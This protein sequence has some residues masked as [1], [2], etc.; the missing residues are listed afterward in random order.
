MNIYVSWLQL[1][2]TM[3]SAIALVCTSVG[4]Y[5]I[6]IF[7]RTG[8]KQIPYIHFCLIIFL[9]IFIYLQQVEE[10]SQREYTTISIKFI[11]KIKIILA[12]CKLCSLKYFDLF[13]LLSL[14]KKY[15]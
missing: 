8:V 4:M 2:S 1:L 6:T 13:L 12:F 7:L 10:V 3:S 14:I 11:T 9:S 15:G 5:L